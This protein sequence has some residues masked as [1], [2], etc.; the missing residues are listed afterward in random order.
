[1][2]VL[3]VMNAVLFICEAADQHICPQGNRYS[4]CSVAYL[5]LHISVYEGYAFFLWNC[6][7]RCRMG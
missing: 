1:M 3:L 6:V 7:D 4:S 5:V 2:G